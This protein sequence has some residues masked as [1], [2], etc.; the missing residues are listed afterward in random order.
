VSVSPTL[1]MWFITYI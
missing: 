1:S